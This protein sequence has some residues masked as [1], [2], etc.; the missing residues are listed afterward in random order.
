MMYVLLLPLEVRPVRM[1]IFLLGVG[2][3]SGIRQ[4]NLNGYTL[5]TACILLLWWRPLWNAG[6]HVVDAVDW[7]RWRPGR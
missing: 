1:F 4:G 6:M 5:V 2:G 7:L 3:R